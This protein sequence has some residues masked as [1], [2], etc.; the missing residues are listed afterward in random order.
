MNSATDAGCRRYRLM[1]A[2]MRFAPFT[3]AP[4]SRTWLP[5]RPYTQLDLSQATRRS[6]GGHGCHRRGARVRD[7][8]RGR[9][10]AVATGD[11]ARE[12]VVRD[13][14]PRRGRTDP[15]SHGRADLRVAVERAHANADPLGML[16]VA[17]EDRGSTHAAEPFLAAVVGLPNPQDILTGNDAERV[18]RGMGARR[19]RRARSPLAATAMTVARAEQLRRDLITN[20]CA[21]AA[22][23]DGKRRH[24][25]IIAGWGRDVVRRQPPQSV[26]SC[27]G[28]A[29]RWC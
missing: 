22:T 23:G 4:T 12:T 16:V 28:R 25:R 5:R 18:N 27:R 3:L 20:R 13:R 17:C 14:L 29:V 8:A 15:R 9:V 19:G 2:N 21:V 24:T 26:S 11:V 1:L 7:Q 10:S 6:S